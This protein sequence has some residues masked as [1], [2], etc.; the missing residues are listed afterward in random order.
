MLVARCI[1]GGEKC[2]DGVREQ[3]WVGEAIVVAIG[4]LLLL[5]LGVVMMMLRRSRRAAS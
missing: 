3:Q 2:V 5:V 1:P 4:V